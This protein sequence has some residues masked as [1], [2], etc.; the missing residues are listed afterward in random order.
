MGKCS[1]AEDAGDKSVRRALRCETM[2]VQ[3]SNLGPKNVRGANH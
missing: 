3:N 1:V 2:A